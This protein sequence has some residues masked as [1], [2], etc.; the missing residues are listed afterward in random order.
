MR[1]AL[2][3]RAQQFNGNERG[4]VFL[5]V[6]AFLVLLLFVGMAVDFGILL[7]YRRAMQ[8]GCDSS[9]MAG[10][11]D[12]TTSGSTA[13]ATASRYAQRDYTENNIT[14][15]SNNFTSTPEDANGNATGTSPVRLAA[16]YTTTVPL[17]FLASVAPSMTINVACAAQRVPVLTTGL[18]PLG[19][20][21]AVYTARW[22]AQ[23][24]K[25]C[26]V[27]GSAGNPNA[28]G[29]QCGDCA[30]SININGSG[31]QNSPASFCDSSAPGSGN[32]GSLDLHNT[33]AG[34][35]NNGFDTSG[36]WGCTF[37]NGT[38]TNPAYCA[39]SS[40]SNNPANWPACAT[41]VTKTG[42]GVGPW[43]TAVKAVCS[44]PDPVTNPGA[45]GWV[46]VMPLMNSSLWEG[47]I[48]G[49]STSVDIVGFAAFEMDCAFMAKNGY[50][51]IVGTFVQILDYQG[52]TGNP[53]GVDTGVDTIILVQ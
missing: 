39:T 43:N 37:I 6:G 15:V 9:V 48:N 31:T 16:T 26:A 2:G 24:S 32:T 21:K 29:T 30:L 12:L 5:V 22:T 3:R 33:Q 50:E 27:F 51:P 52:T 23:G 19:L 13:Q 17:F 49:R 8:N 11:M 40:T 47:Q 53:N 25:P 44:T 36:G 35:T 41:V 20:D 4:S 45:S 28:L 10:A 34:C 38:G 46:V 42:M 14:W 18:K 7:R 1:I